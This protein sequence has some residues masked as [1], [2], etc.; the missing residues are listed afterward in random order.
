MSAPQPEHR[1]SRPAGTQGAPVGGAVDAAREAADDTQAGAR[2]VLTEPERDLETVRRRVA[3][4]DDGDRGGGA[5]EHACGPER[6]R[7]VGNLGQ[8]G[9]IRRVAERDKAQPG[10]VRGEHGR[11]GARPQR[12]RD[13][14]PAVEGVLE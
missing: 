2:E 14:R 10:A 6:R 12:G 4:A 5:G 8:E 7:R 9:W 11:A 3:G 1:D 13:V